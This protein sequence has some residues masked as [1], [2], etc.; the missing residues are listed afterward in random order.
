MRSDEPTRKEAGNG[1]HV[2]AL[3]ALSEPKLAFPAEFLAR[4]GM[5]MHPGLTVNRE[6]APKNPMVPADDS[7]R[8]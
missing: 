5:F 2:A 6:T 1:D 4:A 8:Y 3:D 7:Q